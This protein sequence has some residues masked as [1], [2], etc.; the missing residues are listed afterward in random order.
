[1]LTHSLAAIQEFFFHK[2]RLQQF[3]KTELYSV[4]LNR[5]W[6]TFHNILLLNKLLTVRGM[7]RIV[8]LINSNT[9]QQNITVLLNI[10][11]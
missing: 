3:Q 7:E 1:M 8:Y 5:K 2:N 11:K 10:L 9:F 4:A 6:N